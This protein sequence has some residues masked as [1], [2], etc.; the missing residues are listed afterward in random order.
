VKN[1]EGLAEGNL[2]VFLLNQLLLAVQPPLQSK[3]SSASRGQLRAFMLEELK[4]W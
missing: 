4:K 3:I 2:S 1:H